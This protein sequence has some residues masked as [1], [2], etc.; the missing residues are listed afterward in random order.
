MGTR[1]IVISSE[2]QG[3]RKLP[4]SV[5]VACGAPLEHDEDGKA[6][7]CLDFIKRDDPR[8]VAAIEALQ[9][10]YPLVYRFIHIIA[11]PDDVVCGNHD[12]WYVHAP[13]QYQEEIHE[14]HRV[15][16][17]SHRA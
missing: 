6:Y 3:L 7:W 12:D 10:Q 13:Y 5:A 15:W 16:L 11:I 2:Y 14:A 17:A 8:L 9:Q 4:E 1:K